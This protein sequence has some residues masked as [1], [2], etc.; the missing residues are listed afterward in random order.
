M[1]DAPEARK[2]PSAAQRAWLRHGLD[3]PGGKLPL[4]DESGKQVDARTIR[5]CIEQGWAE[6]WFNNPLKQDWLVCKITPAGRALVERSRRAA[7]TPKPARLG[8]VVP[9]K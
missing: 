8:N 5:S 6:P 3:Q 9:F 4:F 7:P 2:P 1:N